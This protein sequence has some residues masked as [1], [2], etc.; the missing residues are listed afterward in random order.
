MKKLALIILLVYGTLA[1]QAQ[2]SWKEKYDS[3]SSKS[4]EGMYIVYKQGKR[5]FVDEKSGKLV[6][7]TM[8][9]DAGYFNEGFARVYMKDEKGDLKVGIIDKTGKVVIHPTCRNISELGDGFFAVTAGN[10]YYLN[11]MGQPRG[12]LR[13][14]YISPSGEKFF[15][16]GMN[17]KIGFIDDWA[18][19]K[20]PFVYDQINGSFRDGQVI[21]EKN[22]KYY[23][24][25]KE[26]KET[27]LPYD[28]VDNFNRG[29]ARVSK[30]GMLGFIDKKGNP[31]VPCKYTYAEDFRWS[32]LA[33]VAIRSVT[34]YIDTTGTEVIPLIYNYSGPFSEGLAAVKMNTMDSAG[35]KVNGKYGYIDE[36]GKQ[37]IASKFDIAG[38]FKEGLAKVYC[39]NKYGF[40]DKTGK[41]VIACQWEDAGNFSYGLASVSKDGKWGFIDTNG[42]LVIPYKFEKIHN[43]FNVWGEAYVKLNGESVNINNKG[44][45]TQ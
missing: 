28:K 8:Y 13:F 29:L 39:K 16:A 34:G 38:E 4:P 12:I 19:Q 37:V 24:L 14:S 40:I 5:G 42:T 2:K 43:G 22:G 17:D 1:S 33:N 11:N 27:L 35:Y 15:E 23:V 26:G 18:Q 41:E 21:A 32:R 20:I 44:E 31:V 3:V 36:N 30:A 7:K 25:T 45:K 10:E 9:D 6:I